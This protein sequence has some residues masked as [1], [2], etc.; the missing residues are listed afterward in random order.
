M[1]LITVTGV[2]FGGFLLFLF[3]MWATDAV[4]GINEPTSYIYMAVL[5]TISILIYVGSKAYR[6]K[7][8][9]NFNTRA[10]R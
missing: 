1:P 10:S 4:Y 9:I 7:Q 2:I 6:K 5:Y 8:G 3:Y